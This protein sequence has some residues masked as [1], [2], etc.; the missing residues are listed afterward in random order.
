MPCSPNA[1]LRPASTGASI[2]ALI[3]AGT[4][5]AIILGL[6][7][8]GLAVAITPGDSKP[9][10]AAIVGFANALEESDR[11]TRGHSERVSLYSRMIC[12]GLGLPEQQI[13]MIVLA[14]RFNRISNDPKTT[15]HAQVDDQ[16][17]FLKP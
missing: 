6:I 13:D 17:A 9:L 4:Y 14:R 5:V 10:A 1:F 7:L 12:E 15:R 16:R 2:N 8:G 3:E 11:Y